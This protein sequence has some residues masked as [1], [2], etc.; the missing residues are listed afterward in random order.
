MLR[1]KKIILTI[2][3]FILAHKTIAQVPAFQWAR[4]V[5][6]PTNEMGQSITND[7]SGNVYVTGSFA[8][9]VDF[10][11]G[12]GTFTLAPFGGNDIF[13]L[14][15]DALG[16]FIWVKQ[17]GG[18]MSDGA[19]SIKTDP[20]GNLLISCGFQ[21]VA[22]FDPGPGTFTLSGTGN[23]A[24]VKLNSLGNFV[25]A[26]HINGP[27]GGSALTTDASG[28]V[29]VTGEANGTTDFD[30][31]P[32]TV[33]L[34]QGGGGDIFVLKLTASGT[35]GWAFL[36]GDNY[37]EQGRGIEVDASGNVYV[38]G[39]F[40]GIVDFDP[41]SGVS[42][43]TGDSDIF[44]LKL[45]SSGNYIWAKGMGS[46]YTGPTTTFDA[47]YDIDIDA[48]GN[49]YTTGSF[50]GTADFNPG[51]GTYTLTSLGWSDIFVSKL[52]ASGNFVWAD[53][54]G[55]TN[56]DTGEG[57]ELDASGNI[58]IGG[59][60]NN[61]VDFD[62]GPG[63]Y[64]IS[65]AAYQDVCIIKL[66]PSGSLGWV[67]TW[68]GASGDQPFDISL[69]GLGGIYTTGYYQ[70]VPDCDPGSGTYT[71]GAVG[72][73]DV[74]IHKLYCAVVNASITTQSNV[75]CFGAANGSVS[76]N[77]SGGTGLTYS[78][79]P[80]GAGSTTLSGLAPG[81][82][83]CNITNQCG[84]NALKTV[85]ITQP[86]VL[87][88]TLQVTNVLCYG[89]AT[90]AA[91]VVAGGGVPGYT[92]MWSTTQTSSVITGLVFGVKTVTVTDA[93][94]CQTTA[95][96]TVGQPSSS[97]SANI[98][99]TPVLCNGGSTGSAT[100]SAA[101][102]TPLYTYSWTPSGGT[103]ANVGGLSPGT[104]TC[105]ITDNNSCQVSKTIT[106]TQPPALTLTAMTNPLLICVGNA[107]TLSATAGGGTGNITYSWSSGS[108]GSVVTVAPTASTLYVANINDVNGCAKSASVMVNVDECAGMDKFNPEASGQGLKFKAYP[109]PN[110]GIFTIEVEGN[111]PATVEVIN[112]IGQVVLTYDFHQQKILDITELSNGIYFIKITSNNQ[113]EH[114]RV[115][116][117]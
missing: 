49:V 31:G 65:S 21:G 76:I 26:A 62:P 16:N 4:S 10:D 78:W 109:N 95:S 63:T 34:T 99:S 5:G 107:A 41:G 83:T 100:V 67:Q 80:L 54:F 12:A 19:S 56:F 72:G 61:T 89:D 68:G 81:I 25:W 46:P 14:K 51:S 17:M 102:G 116:K 38:T 70:L 53:S 60:F 69:D 20:S 44:V 75:T 86:P 66:N 105:I 98:L 43:L 40:N 91:T 28:N 106:V 52:D 6:S 23:G 64:T 77:A 96:V 35:Y 88:R 73:S 87:S 36:I 113:M 93:N 15:L 110:E 47:G 9:T 30:P 33:N 8:D 45:N 85:T 114:L 115:V 82:Y 84:S 1:I 37:N 104:Y 79:S 59:W 18:T 94:G 55:G 11:P 7:A 22:D 42:N 92:Y 111:E 58:Y 71:L 101:G 50:R 29:Y 48:S 112:A 39:V 57:L 74:F 117:E 3:V 27:T 32:G 24:I 13:V 108:T 2:S 103:L 97:L 90:G